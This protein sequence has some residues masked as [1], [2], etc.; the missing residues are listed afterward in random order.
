M[1]S[2]LDLSLKTKI[3][4]SNK[5]FLTSSYYLYDL[6]NKDN[7]RSYLSNYGRKKAHFINKKNLI[8]LNNK[9]IFNGMISKHVNISKIC[10]VIQEGNLYP[11][12][13]GE[14]VDSVLKLID[15]IKEK[16]KR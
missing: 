4:L 14:E 7:Y 16:R 2:N 1:K 6:K 9:I 8:I 10:S 13:E 11:Y 5:G 3:K 15:L 12:Y